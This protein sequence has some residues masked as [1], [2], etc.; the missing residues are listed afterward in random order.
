MRIHG[1][2][3]ERG[4]ALLVVLFALILV[5]AIG[6]GLMFS[7]NGESGVSFGYRN[8]NLSFFAARSGVEEVRDRMRITNSPNANGLQ[9]FLPTVPIGVAAGVLYVTNP[10]SGETVAPWDG[11]NPYFDDELCHEINSALIPGSPGTPNKACAP[12]QLPSTAGWYVQKPAMAMPGGALLAYKWARVNL[13]MNESAAPWCVLGIGN[14][15]HLNPGGISA[16]QVCYNGSNEFVLAKMDDPMDIP[17]RVDGM[18]LPSELGMAV[19]MFGGSSGHGVSGHSSTGGVS[20]SSS[21]VGSS[22]S[23]ASASTSSSSSA[24]SSSSS[25]TSSSGLAGTGSTSSTSSSGLAGTGSI[26]TTSS[27][28]LAGTGSISTTSTSSTSST[29]TSS[30]GLAS[31]STPAAACGTSAPPLPGT[32]FG[33]GSLP[34][35]A[36]TCTAVDTQPVYVL[37]A[38]ALA[39]TSASINRA[40]RMVQFDVA[41]LALPPT[42]SALTVMGPTP[43]GS[44]V[45]FPNSNPYVVNGHDVDATYDPVRDCG[46]APAKPAIGTVQDA[47]NPTTGETALQVASDSRDHIINAI[48]RP[49]HYTGADACAAGQPDVQNVTNTVNSTFTTPA[50]L[51]NLVQEIQHSVTTTYGNNPT[52]SSF[53]SVANPQVTVVDGNLTFGPGSGAGILLVTGT[54]TL[55]GDFTFN[56]SIYVIGAGKV[57]AGG[58][59]SGQITGAVV[60][61]NIADNSGCPNSPCYTLNPTDKS[62]TPTLGVPTYDWSGGGGNGIQY[63]SCS[64]KAALGAANFTVISRREITY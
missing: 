52:I 43:A 53:G 9:N 35:A 55:N 6:L 51:N 19:A 10:R 57:V 29:S 63:S 36:A 59:G 12:N 11:T 14:C 8:S 16:D 38:M 21:S 50:G 42:P 49:D 47:G 1:P 41:R 61:A 34:V 32:P 46:G 44:T 20:S 56:G 18:S 30:S 48:P 40:R 7:T 23:S 58:G 3:S 25:S 31:T 33:V 62:Y 5:T 45:L 54:L 17:W 39:P 22:S 60:V 37:T 26:S 28:G 4:I 24:G 64:L 2:K 13:K 15:T 27:S